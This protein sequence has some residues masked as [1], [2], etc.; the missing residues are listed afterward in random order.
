MDMR[1]KKLIKR[2]FEEFDRRYEAVTQMI[3]KCD[4]DNL[5]LLQKVERVLDPFK[6][7]I[8]KI[9]YEQEIMRLRGYIGE[10]E[11]KIS[12]KWYNHVG[13]IEKL[14]HH[15]SDPIKHNKEDIERIKEILKDKEDVPKEEYDQT[16]TGIWRKK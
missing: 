13:L 2:M 14:R 5:M 15:F 11:S 3:Y 16:G 9:D 1:K 7:F 10:V 4:V 12:N 8:K 6:L